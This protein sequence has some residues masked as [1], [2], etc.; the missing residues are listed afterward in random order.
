VAPLTSGIYLIHPLVGY[1]L[2]PFMG[3]GQHPAAFIILAVCVSAVVTLGLTKTP[4]KR[5]V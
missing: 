5:F 4:L 3:A 2:K 1:G